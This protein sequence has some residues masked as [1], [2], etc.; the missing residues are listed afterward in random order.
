MAPSTTKGTGT[1]SEL[2][3]TAPLPEAESHSQNNIDVSV[4]DRPECFTSTLQEC[5][6]VLTAT[7]SIGMSSFLYGICTVITAPIGRD[8][9]MTSAEITWINA[10]SAY[11]FT[12]SNS[13]SLNS[14]TYFCMLLT[15]QIDSL[16][17]LSSF[18]S[19]KLQIPLAAAHY[20]SSQW[21][22]SLYR[23]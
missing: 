18:F 2:V 15:H 8:L 17:A 11:V 12:F 19:P 5:L 9:N 6:F 1:D 16:L 23:H 22:P 14:S 21:V 10:S 13:I 4:G 3:I 20:L 7:M